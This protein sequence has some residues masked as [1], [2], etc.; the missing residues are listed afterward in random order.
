[1]SYNPPTNKPN[2]PNNPRQH[3]QGG[4]P[5][6]GGGGPVGDSEFEETIVQVSRVSKKT[7]GGNQIGFS[8]LAVVGDKKG[9]IGVGIGKGPDVASSIR[10]GFAQAKKSL[11]TVNLVN[12]S[13]PH[14]IVFKFG[15]AE[16]MLKPAA[17]G[18][19]LIAGGAVRA[20]LDAAGVKD[21]V[22]KILGS[23]NPVNNVYCTFEALRHL[24]SREQ[25][26]QAGPVQ[27][28]EK[29]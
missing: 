3:G 13:V 10:K 22:S 15:A 24:K 8:V 9:R 28:S 5:R 17:P 21:A 6:R 11:I 16:V 1:M 27:V 20:V 26:R 2:N 4:R 29:K 14:R 12:N 25:L 19:G 23:N 18:T 7:K